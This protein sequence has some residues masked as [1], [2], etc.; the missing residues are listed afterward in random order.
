M[1]PSRYDI[2]SPQF[3]DAEVARQHLEAMRWP[4]GP[5]CPHCDSKEAYKLT[6]KPGS[7]KPVRVGVYKCADCREQFTVTI[8]TIFEDSKIP[9][10]KWLLAIHLLSASKKGMSAH[11]L[12]R[13]LGV[14]YK[15]AWFM[16]HRIRYAMSQ[17]PY[18]A[19]KLKGVVEADETYVGG[20]QKGGRGRMI[21]KQKRPVFSVV[22]R[23]GEVRSFH[24]AN[25]T[26]DTLG[27]IIKR[28][29]DR[30]AH[31]CTD[32]FQSYGRVGGIFAAHQTVAHSKGEFRKGYA[33]TNTI[34]GYFSLLKR[35]LN[36]IY[37]KVSQEHLH[38]Y[39]AE[40]DFRYN[41]RKL[42]DME[43]AE[44]MLRASIGKRLLLREPSSPTNLTA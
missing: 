40:F 20:V 23:G 12:H 11:Q 5:I 44:K 19:E 22:K 15:S 4:D 43:R 30:C 7:K 31:L 28:N 42:K 6:A 36:G 26:A 33:H 34:E 2:G 32:E 13:M 18:S 1:T 21:S 41:N 17:S 8:G 29:V 3:Q 38:R 14:A 24:V 9:L 16:A 39:L 25:V 37:H 27:D 35:G 10:N